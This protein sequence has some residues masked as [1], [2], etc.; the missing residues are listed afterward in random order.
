MARFDQTISRGAKSLY[1]KARGV[2]DDT[3]TQQPVTPYDPN[4]DNYSA[5][6]DQ[7]YAQ[8]QAAANQAQGQANVNR[9]YAAD[10]RALNTNNADVSRGFAQADRGAT[11][12]SIGQVQADAG[13]VRGVGGQMVDYANQGPGPSA[14]EA[15]LKQAQDRNMRNAVALAR[16]GRGGTGG[17]LALRQADQSRAQAQTDTAAQTSL[18]RAQEADAWRGRQLEALRGGADAYNAAGGLS[19]SVTGSYLSQQQNDQGLMQNDLD[20]QRNQIEQLRTN[21]TAAQGWED[22]AQGRDR[23]AYDYAALDQEGRTGYEETRG[24]NQMDA[25]LAAA[26]YDTQRDSAL[27]GMG[28]A[29]GSAAVMMSDVRAKRRIRPE[30]G[31]P[32]AISPGMAEGMGKL[33]D[34]LVARSAQSDAEALSNKKTAQA[35]GQ[36]AAL[37]AAAAAPGYSYEYK[38]PE[39][40][41]EGRYVGPMAQDLEKTPV[42][43]TVVEDTPQGKQIDTSRLSLVN[44][45]AIAEQQRE[46]ERLRREARALGGARG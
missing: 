4:R 33:S 34:A 15:Q 37:E 45:A 9:G 38:D 41:G 6:G 23:Q 8:G 39:K 27:L 5:F 26:G 14:A 40:H 11:I 21:D 25:Q 36:A 12:N 3:F 1:R 19:D 13:L 46:I 16:S 44:T 10:A 42:G 31:I 20:Q 22:R 29:L 35:S 28:G 30:E 2:A 18:L 17:A 32:N 24:G 7:G 43:S